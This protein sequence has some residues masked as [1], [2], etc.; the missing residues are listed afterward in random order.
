MT[1]TT[2]I[3]GLPTIRLAGKDYPVKP[4]VV[5]Q[6]RIVVPAMMRLRGARLDTITEAQFD[7][8]VEIAFTAVCPC[9]PGLTR[10]AFTDLPI[11][12]VELMKAIGV[13][14]E[15]SGMVEGENPTGE[16]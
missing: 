11:K 12:A 13:I 14:A 10:D 4:L 8:L 15:Q 6:L 3:S 1:Q 2:D 7:D 9:Q 16:A 5:K